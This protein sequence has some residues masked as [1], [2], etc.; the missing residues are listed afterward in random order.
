MSQERTKA[1]DAQELALVRQLR[2]EHAENTS[3]ECPT[4]HAKGWQSARGA[5]LYRSPFEACPGDRIFPA[6]RVTVV[7]HDSRIRRVTRELRIGFWLAVVAS[8]AVGFLVSEELGGIA[9]VG[10]AAASAFISVFT[11]SRFA[12]W[13][14]RSK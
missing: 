10:V 6:H 8:S 14:L 9:G 7:S 11:L 3:P 4:C 5:C 13:I 1:R 12:G 2:R